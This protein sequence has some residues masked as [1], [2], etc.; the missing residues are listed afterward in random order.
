MRFVTRRSAT[1]PRTRRRALALSV[2]L[3]VLTT[4]GAAVVPAPRAALA[5]TATTTTALNLRS[6]PGTGYSV[7]AVMPAGSTVTLLGTNQNGFAKVTYANMTGWAY[8]AYLSQGGSPAPGGSGT[9]TA[10]T[11]TALNLRAGPSF[12]DHVITVMPYG[13]TVTL[14]GQSS[15]GFVS[16]T[17]NGTAGW[18]YSAYL[19]SGG[20]GTTPSPSPSPSPSPAPTSGSAVATANLNLRSGPGT[21]YSI[22]T[23]I[24]YGASVSLTG[25]SQNGY[26]NVYYGS[27]R[28]WASATY[29]N[30]GGAPSPGNGS[31]YTT[32]QIIQIIYAA[33]DRYG[34]PRED[35]LRVARCESNLDP[36]A[37]NPAGSY[38]LFQFVPSTWASTPYAGYDIFDPWASA[39][40]AGWMWSQG[41][42]GE[43]VCQ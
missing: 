25:I 41:R 43:W 15:N 37:V 5:A 18:A 1:S 16:V 22:L 12:A 38:G 27:V 30:V 11:T 10:K 40:A 32:D 4:V 39:N 23:V 7:M 17:Y 2:A 42:R 13:A 6:G 21:G 31:G 20:S 34:Q 14:T 8:S 36:N 26:Y 9:G 35:M 28:G 24:P 33:A 3:L 29:L 19:T